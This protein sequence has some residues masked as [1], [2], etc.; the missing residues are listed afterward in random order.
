MLRVTYTG[1]DAPQHWLFDPDDVDFDEAERIETAMGTTSRD[2]WDQFVAGVMDAKVRARRVLLW[3]LLRRTNP[4]YPMA[5]ADT[6]NAKM[7]QLTVELGTSEIAK[8]ASRFEAAPLAP[9]SKAA[10]LQR[11][12]EEFAVAEFAESAFPAGDVT[13][14]PKDATGAV[15]TTPTAEP[16][17]APPTDPT[18]PSVVSG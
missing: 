6:P 11:L 16:P 9:A 8:L 15:G 14:D 5:F 17:E 7:G 13:A 18:D 10:A 3:H 2:T 1:G 4:D 12:T